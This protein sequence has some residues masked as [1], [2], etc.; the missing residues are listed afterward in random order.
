MLQVTP[1]REM[2]GMGCEKEA[3]T[4]NGWQ[5]LTGQNSLPG[6]CVHALFG[7]RAADWVVIS[8]GE[9]ALENKR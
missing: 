2:E 4:D 7:D 9:G 6:E 1:P 5:R 8:P 3:D